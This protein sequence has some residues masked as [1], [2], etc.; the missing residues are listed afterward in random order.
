[1]KFLRTLFWA[2]PLALLVGT[3]YAADTSYTLIIKNHQFVP[4]LLEV[5]A[6]QKIKLVRK[7]EDKTPEEFESYD[8]HREK[9]V[10]GG[11]SITINLGPLK[12]G[13]YKFFGEFNPKTAQGSLVAK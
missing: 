12:P 11:K 9:V 3:A 7:N 6:G 13:T 10:A 8:L 1:M 5:P 4:A 2:A